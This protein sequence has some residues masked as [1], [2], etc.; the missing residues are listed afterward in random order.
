MMSKK[1]NRIGSFGTVLV[2]AGALLAWA[3]PN[4]MADTGYWF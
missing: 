2:A 3:P 1:M 4:A